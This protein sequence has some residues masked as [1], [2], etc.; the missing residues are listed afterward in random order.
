MATAVVTGAA[1]GIGRALAVRL[2]G[3]GHRVHLADLSPTGEL[4]AELDGVSHVVDVSAYD[5]VERLAREV[6]DVD[7]LCLNA[8]IVGAS[9]GPPW[10]VPPEEWQRVLG[11]NLLGVVYGLRAFVPRLIASGRPASL[12]VTGSLAGL[13]SFPGGGAYAASKHA[14]VAVVEQVALALA[15]TPVSVTLLRSEEWQRVL[16]VN[17]LGVVYGL[18]A[19]VPRLI[20]SGRPASLLVTGSLAGLVSFPGGGAYAASKHALVAVVEQVALALAGTPV[21]VTLL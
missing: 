11:V 9:M 17:L 21:S 19:F 1:G 16:G 2:A 13:V 20:A 12:L 5:D 4:A 15:G 10:E 6:P 18:R 8:G 14:L 7:V 3:Q